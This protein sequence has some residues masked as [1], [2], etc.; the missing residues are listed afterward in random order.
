MATMTIMTAHVTHAKEESVASLDDRDALTDVLSSP[1]GLI[2]QNFATVNIDR[3]EARVRITERLVVLCD[4]GVFGIV[5]SEK[6]P[7]EF[8]AILEDY[9]ARTYPERAS[10]PA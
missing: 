6:Q 9:V 8:L 7:Y 3:K 4:T 1:V 2:P 10:A 5:L